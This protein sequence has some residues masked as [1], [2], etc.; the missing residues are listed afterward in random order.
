MEMVPQYLFDPFRLYSERQL[1]LA[2]RLSAIYQHQ[3][4][5]CVSF[6]SQ[7]GYGPQ[8]GKLQL[9]INENKLKFQAHT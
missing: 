4:K 8:M 9:S 1:H 6:L 2:G 5:T 3:H 7:V